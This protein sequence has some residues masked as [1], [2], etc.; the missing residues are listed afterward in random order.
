MGTLT[1]ERK[2]QKREDQKRFLNDCCCFL[3]TAESPLYMIGAIA[4]CS[5]S[6]G[7]FR[8]HI[9][10]PDFQRANSVS[11]QNRRT[12]EDCK[13]GVWETKLRT[14]NQVLWVGIF[15]SKIWLQ[16]E[17]K[18]NPCLSETMLL[19]SV[20]TCHVYFPVWRWQEL[21]LLQ[22]QVDCSLAREGEGVKEKVKGLKVIRELES[23]IICRGQCCLP[24]YAAHYK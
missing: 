20:M 16:G 13:G 5:T 10:K 12:N 17:N 6:G 21:H 9:R 11:E 4:A 23:G 24:V 2:R 19:R 18:N 22:E 1:R 15:F 8:G 3:S 7:N 14:A